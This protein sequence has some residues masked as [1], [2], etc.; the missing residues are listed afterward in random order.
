M[1]EI[2]RIKGLKFGTPAIYTVVTGWALFDPQRGG[3]FAFSVDR[4]KE[5]GILI[6][7]IPCGGRKALQAI[8]DA[9]GFVTEEGM[10]IVQSF[11]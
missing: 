10:E 3:Y 7:Y 5:T 6:P 9:G 8:I 4:D 1:M 2:K 11:N